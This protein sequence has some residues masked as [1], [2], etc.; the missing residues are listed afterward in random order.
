M[1]FIPGWLPNLIT[2]IRIGLIPVFLVLVAACNAALLATEPATTWR[3]G[4]V[5][6]YCT[7][8]VSD[9]IDGYLARKYQLTTPFGA[10]LDAVADKLA[11]ISFLLFFTLSTGPGFALLPVW[12]LCVVLARDFI[13]AIGWLLLRQR[14]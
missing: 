10:T 9:L 1:K 11:Q 3:L 12:F 8:G 7:I 4:A 5:S 2:L 13:L 14:R 6:V